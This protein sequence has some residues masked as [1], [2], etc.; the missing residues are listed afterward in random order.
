MKFRKKITAVL[1]GHDHLAELGHFGD[2]PFILSG[3]SWS[4]RSDH[5]VNGIQQGTPI[6]TDWYFDGVPYCVK[7]SFTLR[8]RVPQARFD[9]VRASDDQVRCTSIVETG[10]RAILGENCSLS[11]PTLPQ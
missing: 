8:G 3:A 5:P 7:L 9:F 1:I 4:V 11:M 2:I 6:S 10:A